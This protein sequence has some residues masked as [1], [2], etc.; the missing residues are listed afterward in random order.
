MDLLTSSACYLFMQM[1]L[2][3]EKGVFKPLKTIKGLKEGQVIDVT[4]DEMPIEELYEFARAGG[5]FDF[6]LEDE[7]LY[8]E[9]DVIEP[10]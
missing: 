3:Y 7:D 10:V 8:T 2:K 4:I 1:K 9:D 6:L 5:S